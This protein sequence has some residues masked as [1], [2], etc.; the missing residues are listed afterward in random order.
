MA[1]RKSKEHI[2]I[3][4]MAKQD[5]EMSL[6]ARKIVHSLNCKGHPPCGTHPEL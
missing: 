5:Y 4:C 2:Y 6:R 3:S 1:M